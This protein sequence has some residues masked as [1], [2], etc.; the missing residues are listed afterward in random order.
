MIT[1]AM[2]QGRMGEYQLQA[3]IAAVH[4]Q[5]PSHA[6]T[7]WGKILALYDRL[8][9]VTDNPMVTLNRAAAAGIAQGTEHGL[10]IL[11]DVADRLGDTIAST[12]SERTCRS[13]PV[14]P[15]QRRPASAWPPG[16]RATCGSS[17]TS[18]ARPPASPSGER[19]PLVDGAVV[20]R[21]IHRVPQ[22]VG[23]L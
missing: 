14:T 15:R 22:L 18:P 10:S 13:W 16:G 9:Q 1:A 21:R 2:D 7:E 6:A 8:E 17:T 3:A 11:D 5:A 23:L 20:Q 12:R 4:D 19:C